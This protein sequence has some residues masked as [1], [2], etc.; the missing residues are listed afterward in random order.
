MKKDFLLVLLF[1]ALGVLVTHL[2][3]SPEKRPEKEPDALEVQVKRWPK[4]IRVTMGSESRNYW[5]R[6]AR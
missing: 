5:R 4:F 2:V 1:A 6:E 3:L